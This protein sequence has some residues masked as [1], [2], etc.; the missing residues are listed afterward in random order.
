MNNNI[1]EDLKM[2]FDRKL[3]LP[4]IAVAV[5]GI[6]IVVVMEATNKSSG[7]KISESI[8]DVVDSA[9]DGLAEFREEVKDEFDD[10]TD[11]R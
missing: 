9:N 4:V 11:A 6:F 2:K 1:F 3:L 5:V 7:D 10:N 8:G